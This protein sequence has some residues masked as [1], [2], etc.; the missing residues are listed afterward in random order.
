[1]LSKKA[2]HCGGLS[3]YTIGQFQ[4]QGFTDAPANTVQNDLC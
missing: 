1:M 3:V 2:E 4:G